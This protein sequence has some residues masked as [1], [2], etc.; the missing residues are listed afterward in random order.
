MKTLSSPPPRAAASIHFRREIE[1]A[2][3]A[4]VPRDEMSL[5]LTLSDVSQIRRDR[6]LAVE[7]ISFAGGVM[8]FLGVKIQEGGVAVSVLSLPGSGEA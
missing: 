1:K 5:Q 7:D 8:R 3:A 4:G 6:S 2:E